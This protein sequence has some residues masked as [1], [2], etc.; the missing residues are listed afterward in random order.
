MIKYLLLWFPMLIIAIANGILREGFICRFT[1]PI[2]AH[3][4]STL[5]LIILF[6][7]Y[8]SFVIKQNPPA[9]QLQAIMVGLLWLL[10][11]LIFEFGFGRWRGN[12]WDSLLMEYNLLAGRLWILIP[13]WVAIAP[14]LF[15]RYF[16]R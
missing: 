16:S 12:S 7:F 11:T 2:H 3:Q 15:F 4:L 5:T 14:Y 10:L 9:S 6:A 1:E 8:I 13:L